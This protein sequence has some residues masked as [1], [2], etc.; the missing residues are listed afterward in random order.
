MKNYPI[1]KNG[2]NKK[3]RVEA[4]KNIDHAI[5]LADYHVVNNWAVYELFTGGPDIS[6]YDR[7]I[8]YDD[9][10]RPSFFGSNMSNLLNQ[11]KGKI[12]IL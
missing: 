9:F 8:F 6:D 1:Y 2:K 3:I 10:K 4:E 5:E 7:A 12:N 11:I